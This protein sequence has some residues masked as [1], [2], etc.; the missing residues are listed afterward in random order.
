MSVVANTDQ[1]N[2]I[3]ALV[4]AIIVLLLL[5]IYLMMKTSKINKRYETLKSKITIM[6]IR[7]G[8]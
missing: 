6:N 8:E 1:S 5:I 7:V 3:V 4:I 2:I